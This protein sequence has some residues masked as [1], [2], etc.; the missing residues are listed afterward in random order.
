MKT[1][2]ALLMLI[3]ATAVT[4]VGMSAAA[5]AGA[6]ASTG[7][8]WC[9]QGDPPIHASKH[10]SCG[11]AG[12]IVTRWVNLNGPLE[13][14]FTVKSPVT[15]KTYHIRCTLKEY[16]GTANCKGAHGIHVKFS[17]DI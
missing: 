17:T 10:T 11:M 15:R 3:V 8:H 12:N 16:G 4:Y 6:Y 2:I 13:D 9:K 14:P 5:S 1:A 7:W